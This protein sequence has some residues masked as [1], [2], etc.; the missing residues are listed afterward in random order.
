MQPRPQTDKKVEKGRETGLK[1]MKKIL[2][3]KLKSN[4]GGWAFF[5]FKMRVGQ[6]YCTTT[7]SLKCCTRGFYESTKKELEKWKLNEKKLH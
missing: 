1:K 3:F 5:Y 6:R 7:S 2:K 4:D